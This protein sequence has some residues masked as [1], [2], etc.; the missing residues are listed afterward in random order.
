MWRMWR[1]KRGEERRR[2]GVGSEG[3]KEEEIVG[4]RWIGSREVRMAH[5]ER[6]VEGEVGWT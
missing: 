5:C 3:G 4:R 1:K 2:R 6:E